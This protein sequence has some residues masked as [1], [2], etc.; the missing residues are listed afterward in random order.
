MTINKEDIVNAISNMNILEL[1]E[2][3]KLIEQKFNITAQNY[4]ENT[5]SSIE[6][7]EKENKQEEKNTYTITL[8]SYGDNKLNVIKTIRSILDLGLKEAKEFVEKLPATIKEN[9]Q[10][11]DIEK[12]KNALEE[13]GA[14]VEIK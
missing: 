11:S 9:I 7:T 12:I 8:I 5:R 2:L 10:K 6:K 3:T 4:Q 1:T 14:K 13:S